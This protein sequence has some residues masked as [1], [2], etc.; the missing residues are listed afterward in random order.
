MVASASIG[1]V[2]RLSISDNDG[3]DGRIQTALASA[4][5]AKERGL[6]AV[7]SNGSGGSAM[8]MITAAAKDRGLAVAPSEVVAS[9]SK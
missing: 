9:G 2:W 7:K 5:T 1:E 6:A 3:V 4:A 8:M